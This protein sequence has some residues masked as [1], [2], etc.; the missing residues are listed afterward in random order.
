[1]SSRGNIR[2][3]RTI[4]FLGISGSGKGTQTARL[5]RALPGSINLSTGKAFRRFA[6]RPTRVGRFVKGIIER[7]GIMPYWAPAY[8]WLN[9]FF[10]NLRGD[11]SVVFDG[12]PRLVAEARM[13][14]D[15]MRDTG[16]SAPVVIYLALHEQEARRRLLARGR[17]D[18][19]PAAIH[20]RFA[21]FRE[22]VRPVIS[23]Y[24]QRRRLMTV[25]GDQPVPAVW[26][27]IKKALRI[28]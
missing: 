26:R 7:G 15:F 1:M 16:R 6:K 9:A 3:G 5:L 21:W 23:Y 12:A 13:I 25:N 18:D 20:R 19:T 27:D 17:N 28:A 10:E 11:E 8:V 2:G 22:H 14:D 4:V 24:R